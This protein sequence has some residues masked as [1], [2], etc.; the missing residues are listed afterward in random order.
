VD[1]WTRVPGA[2][3]QD[4]PSTVGVF[5]TGPALIG[6]RGLGRGVVSGHP[7]NTLGS[8][9]TAVRLGMPWVEADVRRTQDDV[10]VVAH[11]AIYPDGTRL[12]DVPAAEADRRQTLRLVSL[13][14]LLSPDV[15]LNVDLKSSIGDSLRLPSRT[16]AAL[17]GPVMAAEAGRRPVMV[18][19]FDPAALG[20]LRLESPQVPLGWLTWDH[21]PLEQAVAGCA[22]L[23]VDVLGLHVGSFPRDPRTGGVDAD[24]VRR[25][26]GFVHGCRREL[27][28]WCPE[29][30]TA[31]MLVAVGADAVVVDEVPSALIALRSDGP[32]DA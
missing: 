18:S 1:V 8:F 7:E 11:D 17:L 28:V 27:L 30:S 29:P 25:T 4:P 32:A 26:L 24:A 5:G 21:F 12:T 3:E 14:E 16:T 15:G 20:R 2:A 19:S 22:H 6:H 10:L 23:D 9:T 13:L 31:R